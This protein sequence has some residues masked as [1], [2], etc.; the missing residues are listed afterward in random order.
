MFIRDGQTGNITMHRGDTGAFK[1]RATR[2][3]GESWT[4][5]DRML[6]TVRDSGGETMLQRFYRL[7]TEL[8]SGVMEIQFHNNDTDSWVNGVY[9]A[10]RRYIVAPRWEGTAP[11][12]DCVNAM[13]AGARIVE[14]DVVRV[15]A[16]GQ[17][18]ITIND[19]YGEV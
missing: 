9:Q 8:G 19:I 17:F 1:V 15:P 11:E 12:G 10:E 4:A 6:F 2:T 16:T 3:S 7:D 18:S 13:T 14:G 5:A